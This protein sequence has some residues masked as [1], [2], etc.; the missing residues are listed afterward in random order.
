MINTGDRSAGVLQL[1]L[2][3][4]EAIPHLV[5]EVRITNFHIDWPSPSLAALAG[6]KR[7]GADRLAASDRDFLR[8]QAD[9][10]TSQVTAL[11][12][13][14]HRGDARWQHEIGGR[15]AIVKEIASLVGPRTQW[16]EQVR[17]AERAVGSARAK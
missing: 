17:E 5:G 7:I 16:D 2:F 12:A 3:G 13:E 11:L 9:L 4:D 1:A 15:V 10:A 14:P 6:V 8:S